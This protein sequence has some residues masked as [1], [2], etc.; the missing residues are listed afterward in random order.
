MNRVTLGTFGEPGSGKT[1]FAL[2]LFAEWGSERIA[3][4]SAEKG[5]STL[6]GVIGNAKVFEILNDVDMSATEADTGTKLA[7]EVAAKALGALT[8]AYKA[9]AKEKGLAW[10][11]LDGYTTIS[12][13]LM[14]QL[15]Q[16]MKEG[17]FDGNNGPDLRKMYAEVAWRLGAPLRNFQAL[18]L[19]GLINCRVEQEYEYKKLTNGKEEMTGKKW[20]APALAGRKTGADF[21]A[22]WDALLHLFVKHEPAK[23]PDGRPIIWPNGKDA[24][25]RVFW[26]QTVETPEAK[27]KCRAVEPIPT[28]INLG[29]LD[30]EGNPLTTLDQWDIVRLYRAILG[31]EGSVA[32]VNTVSS[33]S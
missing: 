22:D 20:L 10:W 3:I 26:T 33:G 31:K 25:N 18:P 15:T 12:N 14:R 1:R 23:G 24:T 27:A 28:F 30:P 17:E 19:N 11:I 29:R 6:G 8:R 13:L 4:L 32:T 9:I 21:A 5:L 2:P 7:A 16:K